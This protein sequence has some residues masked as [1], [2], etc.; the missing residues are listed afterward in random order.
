[1]KYIGA[2]PAIPV[3]GWRLACLAGGRV[4]ATFD[5]DP[6]GPLVFKPATVQLDETEIREASASAARFRNQPAAEREQVGEFWDVWVLLGDG[7]F[8]RRAPARRDKPS[9]TE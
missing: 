7:T 3:E 2:D 9:K 6:D 8:S 5:G 1:M 4:G